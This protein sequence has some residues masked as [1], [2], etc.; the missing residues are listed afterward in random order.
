MRLGF[1]VDYV[2]EM[3]VGQARARGRAEE[4]PFA[5]KRYTSIHTRGRL[6]SM[7]YRRLNIT[8]P[9]DL[10]A[11]A[12]AFAAR[13]RY[14]RS[15]LIAS[16]LDAFVSTG[17][18]GADVVREPVTTY[19]RVA[20]AGG[21]GLHPLVRPLVPVIIEAC[22]RH[23]VRTVSLVGSATQADPGVHVGDLDVLVRFEPAPE[24]HAGRYF[25]LLADLE[26]LTGM[27]VDLIEEDAV[28]NVRLTEE[29]T[30]TR[31]VLYERP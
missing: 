13:Q 6:A 16:A 25:G 18:S 19:G 21:V 31:V 4:T 8:L 20:S 22:R 28:R 10:L 26:V 24:G 14:S 5:R 7:E 27:P 11:R 30:R 12:D 15:G 3:P 1:P 17:D 9:K 23:G 29:F 2:A